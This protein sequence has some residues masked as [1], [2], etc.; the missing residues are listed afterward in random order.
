MRASLD[1]LDASTLV[2]AN[3]A[4]LYALFPFSHDWPDAKKYAGPD[5]S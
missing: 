4:N 3:E 2:R 5:L 1:D